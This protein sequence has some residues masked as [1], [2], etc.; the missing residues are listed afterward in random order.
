MSMIKEI[1]AYVDEHDNT[2]FLCPHCGF[3]KQM[4]A[5]KLK[6]QKK[7]LRI[8]CKCG[9]TVDM[10][11]E[12]RR[13]FRKN[14]M[15]LGSCYIE[16]NRSTCNIIVKDISFRGIG[17][18]FVFVNKKNMAAI[19]KDDI[20]RVE[21]TLDNKHADLIKK[22]CIVRIIKKHI[23]GAEFLDEAYSK[24]LGFYLMK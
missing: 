24:R 11:V 7:G 2:F 20:L 9:Q 10:K 21:F 12:F 15:L 16:K 19:A 8:K 5:S 23:I 6:N 13:F 4:N 1:K 22:K 14:V 18:E 17:I 3:K